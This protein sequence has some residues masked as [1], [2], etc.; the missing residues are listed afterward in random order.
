MPNLKVVVIPKADHMT[1]VGNPEF[2]KKLRAFLMEY[3]APAPGKR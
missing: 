2:M 3:S 1:A